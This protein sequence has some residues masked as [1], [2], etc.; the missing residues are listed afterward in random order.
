MIE[1]TERDQVYHAKRLEHLRALRKRIQ[2]DGASAIPKF[3]AHPGRN[4]P[5][6]QIGY[7]SDCDEDICQEDGGGTESD[8]DGQVY[9]I[10]NSM[11]DLSDSDSM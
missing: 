4:R 2:K 5:L 7:I 1:Q 10:E 9:A 3:D 6:Q 8:D 11:E